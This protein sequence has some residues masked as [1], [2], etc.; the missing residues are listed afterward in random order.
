MT[1]MLGLRQ[2]PTVR[3]PTKPFDAEK[4]S[5]GVF[6][7]RAEVDL[8]GTRNDPRVELTQYAG[9]GQ[10]VSPHIEALVNSPQVA[11]TLREDAE[12]GVA[13]GGD[14]W[15]NPARGM[16]RINSIPGGTSFDNFTG[17][18]QRRPFGTRCRMRW[19]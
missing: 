16:G 4:S 17:I 7:P 5:W 1:E 18:G 13:T 12:R 3:T 9:A 19:R 11:R 14:I 2:P 10:K 15:Y 8:Q 6:P